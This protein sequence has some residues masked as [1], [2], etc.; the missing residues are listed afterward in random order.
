MIKR[1]KHGYFNTDTATKVLEWEEGRRSDGT[2]VKHTIY[3]NGSGTR[4]LH[5]EGGDNSAYAARNPYGPAKPGEDIVYLSIDDYDALVK[6][7]SGKDDLAR[8]AEIDKS[9]EKGGSGNAGSVQKHI[10]LS[11]QAA[12]KLEDLARRFGTS[13]N[14]I[15]DQLII[16]EKDGIG[17]LSAKRRMAERCAQALKE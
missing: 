3:R 13:Q 6:Q 2:N 5:S 10:R 9:F 4:F 16:N 7:H 11:P 8:I 15:I 17:L 14:A 1:T 12:K